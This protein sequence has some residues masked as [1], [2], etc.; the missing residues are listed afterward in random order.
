MC[1]SKTRLR[2]TSA[3]KLKKFPL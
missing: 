3:S 1:N 2:L